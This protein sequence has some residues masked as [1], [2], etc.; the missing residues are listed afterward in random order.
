MEG[1]ERRRLDEIEEDL[2]KTT[3]QFERTNLKCSKLSNEL[4]N[5]K[6]GIQ[7]LK[8]L[9][10]FYKIDNASKGESVEDDLITL[11]TKLR[12]IYDVVK[13]DPNYMKY[14]FKSSANAVQA[15]MKE[16]TSYKNFKNS[17]EEDDEDEINW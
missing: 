3:N 13:T 15:M 4:I 6:A 11:N 16:Q 17:A 12:M 7:H 1:K 8:D 5:I 14:N 9:T 2:T 10:V